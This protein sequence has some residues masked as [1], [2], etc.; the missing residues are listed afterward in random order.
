MDLGIY[1]RE[2]CFRPS[3]APLLDEKLI[4]DPLV[5]LRQT[6]L[7]AVFKPFEKALDHLLRAKNKP[8]LCSDVI[9]DAY[10]ALEALAKS[11][12]GRDRDLSANRESFFQ[13][14]QAPDEY[15]QF[16]R[17]YQEYGNR[18]RHAGSRERSKPTASYKMA[19]SFVYVTGMFIRLATSPA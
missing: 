13:K 11:V 9:T 7:E 4:N 12:T 17:A 2:G 6:G 5:G 8:E 15:K 1:W 14:I 3:G 18:F 16:L 10:E 19:E